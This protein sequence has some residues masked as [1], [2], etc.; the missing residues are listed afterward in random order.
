MGIP[1]SPKAINDNIVV[2]I[3]EK[4]LTISTKLKTFILR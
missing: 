1:F 3:Q 2:Q 4:L